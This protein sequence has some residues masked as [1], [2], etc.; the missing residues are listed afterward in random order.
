MINNPPPVPGVRPEAAGPRSSA[1]L[2]LTWPVGGYVWARMAAYL[3]YWGFCTISAV[4]VFQ[5]TGSLTMVGLVTVA[6]FVPQFVL[7]PISGVLADRGHVATQIVLSFMLTGTGSAV[8][9]AWIIAAG[10][11]QALPGAW[12]VLLASLVVGV[13]FAVGSSSTAAVLPSLVRADE[14]GAAVALNSVPL[15][16][17]RA[18][19]PAVGGVLA[20]VAGPASACLVAAGLNLGCG[21]LLASMRLPQRL[22]DERDVSTGL[23]RAVRHVWRDRRLLLVLLGVAAVGL[24]AEPSVTLAP[25]VAEQFGDARNAGW[26]ASA[27]GAGGVV[28]LVALGPLRRRVSHQV[29]A[30][31]GLALMGAGL[32]VVAVGSLPAAILS[33]MFVAGLG[34]TVAHA[35]LATLLQILAPAVMRGRITALWFLCWLGARP[36]GATMLGA[37]A[38]TLGTGWALATVGAIALIVALTCLRVWRSAAARGGVGQSSRT[39]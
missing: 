5:Q 22:N 31:S 19:G 39:S 6:Q 12:P 36:V 23:G 1:S 2:A 20:L 35:N 33:G 38:D 26:V 18:L 3:G 25:A 37:V 7:T 4:A 8:L 21:A 32:L 17:A 15:M 24:A 14:L 30:S 29:G 27:F 34:M 13:G 28:G 16:V 11:V 9:G 10:S